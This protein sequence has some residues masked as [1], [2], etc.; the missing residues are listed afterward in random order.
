MCGAFLLFLWHK[1]MK[2]SPECYYKE[3]EEEFRKQRDRIKAVRNRITVVKLVLF[4]A[5]CYGIYLFAVRRE[6]FFLWL[7]IGGL[8]MFVFFTIRDARIV[9]RIRI[10]EALLSVCRLESA[11]LRG[12]YGSLEGGAS[13]RNREHAY[14]EDLD[15]LGKDSLFQHMN[16]TVTPEGKDTLASWLLNP[17]RTETE[18]LSRQE[19]VRDLAA[20]PDWAMEFRAWGEVYRVTEQQVRELKSWLRE[21]CFFRKPLNRFGVYV[22]NGLTLSCWGFAFLSVIPYFFAIFFS[23]LQLGYI[24]LH[25]KKINVYYKRLGEVV[26]TTTEYLRLMELMERKSFGS[27][28][29]NALKKQLFG[30]RNNSLTAFRK[31]DKILSGFDQRNNILVGFVTNGLYTSDFHFLMNLDEWKKRHQDLVEDWIKALSE[32][33]ALCSMSFYRFNHPRFIFPEPG[34]KEWLKAEQLGHPLLKEEKCVRN[35]FTVKELHH[36]FIVTGANMAGKSTFLR[37]VGVNLVLALSGNVVCSSKFRFRLMDLFTSMRTTDNLAQGTSYFHAELLRLKQLIGRAERSE[38]LFIILDEMLKGTN[39][40]DKVNGS[41]R[42]L[43]HLLNYPV[44]GIIATHDLELGELADRFPGHFFNT[45][46]EISHTADD[47][48]YDY[49]LKEGVSR[50]MNAT[51]LLEKM[52]LI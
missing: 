22:W 37:T 50:N 14:A 38:R 17:C 9:R 36:F 47:I 10:A 28:R 20:D 21:E 45:C 44:S 11:Y 25:L 7:S 19:A 51:I 33:D 18:I 2:M 42:F 15:I 26:K 48:F 40:R 39:S 4:L 13:Y 35:D 34:E 41:L 3:K 46:F 30:G 23:L 32:A 27:V 16:R 49:K 29:M 52:G 43:V 1:L 12:E 6:T 24:S 5:M 31:L 8:A